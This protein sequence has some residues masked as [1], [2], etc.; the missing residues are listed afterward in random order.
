MFEITENAIH[1]D[2]KEFFRAE[3]EELAQIVPTLDRRLFGPNGEA[4]LVFRCYALRTSQHTIMVDTCLGND[5]KRP[6]ERGNML[7]TAFLEDLSKG[8]VEP[9]SV[10]YVF[11]T[12]L[13]F[14]HVGW[15]TRLEN[16][17]WVP[18]FP[19]AKHLFRQ[20]EYDYW[21]TEAAQ[22]WGRAVMADSVAPIVV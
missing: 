7:K 2:P 17:K 12:H 15:N 22:E 19:N 3:P 8:G 4:T 5:K 18:T 10:D 21:T 20:K 13:H 14:D 9:E 6:M 1:T 16:G 11:C